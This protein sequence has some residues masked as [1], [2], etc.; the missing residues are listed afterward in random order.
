MNISEYI[1]DR[2]MPEPNSGCSLWLRSVD[3]DG[4]GW[5][6]WSG[7]TRRA[8]ILAWEGS[9]GPAPSGLCVCHK[10][11][12]P[13][14]VNVDH[15]W[16]GTNADN[17]RDRDDKGRHNF[18]RGEEQY[19][20]RLTETDV[21]A[22][23]ASMDTG[24]ALA[25]RYDVSFQHIS[26]IRSGQAWKHIDCTVSGPTGAA[27]GERSGKAKLTEADVL[28]IRASRGR[29]KDVA[30]VYGI[31]PAYVSQIRNHRTWQHI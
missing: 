18:S 21:L 26:D 8:H 24:R 9:S 28:T 10:C 30:A 4:Y 3:K 31:A 29:L 7:R 6:H 11:D 27:R 15:L 12:N 25:I 17:V 19:V 13:S 22:I 1:A 16:L 23:R 20:S 14:C 5:A 2:S